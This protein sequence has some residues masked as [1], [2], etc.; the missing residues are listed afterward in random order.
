MLMSLCPLAIVAAEVMDIGRISSA[1]LLLV[2]L[3]TEM[4]KVGR[5]KGQVVIVLWEKRVVLEVD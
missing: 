1:F 4:Q 5:R 2:T 3:W